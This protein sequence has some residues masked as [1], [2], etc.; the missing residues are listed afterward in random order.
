MILDWCLHRIAVKSFAVEH[1][2][3]SIFKCCRSV[4]NTF[5]CL[6]FYISQILYEICAKSCIWECWFSNGFRSYNSNGVSFILR[7]SNDWEILISDDLWINLQVVD[8][9]DLLWLFMVFHSLPIY[10][11]WIDQKN[12]AFYIESLIILNPFYYFV[13]SYSIRPS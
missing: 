3:F 6:S 8:L 2:K 12:W 9:K 4:I 7:F 5:C 11:Y 1:M 13:I 10:I